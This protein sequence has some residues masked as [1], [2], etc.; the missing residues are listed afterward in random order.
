[1]LNSLPRISPPN[2]LPPP[3]FSS[4]FI[5]TLNPSAGSKKCNL[6]IPL[7]L[8]IPFPS[9]A[10][11]LPPPLYPYL[12]SFSP[13]IHISHIPLPSI[14][15]S[16]PSP[17]PSIPHIPIPLRPIPLSSIPYIP[18]LLHPYISHPSPPQTILLTS[19]SSCI[20]IYHIPPPWLYQYAS[21]T[22]SLFSLEFF[23]HFLSKPNPL[24][25]VVKKDIFIVRA[26]ARVFVSAGLWCVCVCS[27]FAWEV[28]SNEV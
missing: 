23:H 6:T 4:P 13:S 9:L 10:I 8:H 27:Q 16:Y 22:S 26:Y 20:H 28:V 24:S 7:L 2:I 25:A 21:P 18:L 5:K 12:I 3:P 1:M 14:H 17:P 11:P 19:I 15:I